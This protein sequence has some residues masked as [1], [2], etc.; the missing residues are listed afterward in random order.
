M[1]FVT[2]RLR[3]DQ[4]YDRDAAIREITAQMRAQIR[5]EVD[6][7]S[8][9]LMHFFS[10]A[11]RFLRLMIRS[12]LRFAPVS[13]AFGFQGQALVGLNKVCNL[14]V[15]RYYCLIAALHPPGATVQINQFNGAMKSAPPSLTRYRTTWL[16][17]LLDSVV[18][19]LATTAN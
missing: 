10:R 14:S 9:Q 11:D 8:L 13:L 16:L 15:A 1:T 18:E 5:K 12:T 6:L 7:G 3:A 17:G 2:I 4:L 19:D